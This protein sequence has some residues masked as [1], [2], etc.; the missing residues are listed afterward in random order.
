MLNISWCQHGLWMLLNLV[1]LVWVN[2]FLWFRIKWGATLQFI[3]YPRWFT[4]HAGS[5]NLFLVGGHKTNSVMH[6]DHHVTITSP[7]Q[8]R[9]FLFYISWE[10]VEYTFETNHHHS[11][12]CVIWCVIHSLYVHIFRPQF[13]TIYLICRIPDI[14]PIMHAII[15]CMY[16]PEIYDELFKTPNYS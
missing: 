11:S 9:R 4:Y 14:M 5:N 2:W 12:F 3:Q 16:Q 1:Q 8:S 6:A 13:N 7:D 15:I 10:T